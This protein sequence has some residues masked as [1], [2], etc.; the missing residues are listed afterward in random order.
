M[1][2]DVSP[3][4]KGRSPSTAGDL[5]TIPSPAARPGP[6]PTVA[7]RCSP[8]YSPKRQDDRL[9]QRPGGRRKTSDLRPRRKTPAPSAKETFRTDIQPIVVRT[10]RR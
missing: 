8:A 3:D 2:L 5:Y 7:G 10:R 1:S 4:G 9:N 6:A